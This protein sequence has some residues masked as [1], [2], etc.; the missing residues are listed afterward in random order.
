MSKRIKPKIYISKLNACLPKSFRIFTINLKWKM[1]MAKRLNAKSISK[2][3]FHG[4][5]NNG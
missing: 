5:S 3:M 1:V 4:W 2:I